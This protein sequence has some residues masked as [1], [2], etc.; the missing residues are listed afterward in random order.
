MGE[1]DQPVTAIKHGSNSIATA[2]LEGRLDY[3]SA[4]DIRQELLDTVE[5]GWTRLVVDLDA[6]VFVDSS[7]LGAL[8]GG[9][10]AARAAGGDLHLAAVPEQARV[11]LSLTTL[12]RM[13]RSYG[14][15]AEAIADY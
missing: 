3:L 12:D 2:R 5:A 1:G 10:K 6:V 11:V 15:V 9:L 7:G 13:F 8:I 4:S 14:S